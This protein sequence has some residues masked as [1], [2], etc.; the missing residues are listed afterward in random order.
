MRELTVLFFCLHLPSL[1]PVIMTV[2]CTLTASFFSPLLLP[3]FDINTVIL[4]ELWARI[5]SH[6]RITLLVLFSRKANVG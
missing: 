6:S 2:S 5:A 1:D 4:N 3:E